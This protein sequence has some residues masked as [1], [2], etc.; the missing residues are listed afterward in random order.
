MVLA[1][2]NVN[3][4]WPIGC[5]DRWRPRGRR[6]SSASSTARSSSCFADRLR[7]SSPWARARSSAGVMLWISASQTISGVSTRL[8]EL[9]RRRSLPRHPARVL[10]RPRALRLALVRLRVH[11]GRAAAPVRRPRP[12]R[13]PAER[14]PRRPPA[15]GRARRVRGRSPPS[16]VCSTP[17]RRRRR[18]HLRH[19]LPAARVR[20]GV[21]RAARRSTPGRFNP[22]GAFIAVYFLVDRHHGPPAAGRADASSSSS[23]TAALSSSRSSLSQLARRRQVQEA[24]ASG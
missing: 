21:P 17:A 7:S 20:R 15:L 22:W 2:L 8:V 19:Q 9:G 4:G 3:H 6:W 10:L 23:S 16:P 18:S 13:R 24:G 5:V 11:A 12:Q 14:H 1:I